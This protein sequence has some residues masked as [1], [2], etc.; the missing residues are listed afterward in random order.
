MTLLASA[1]GLG[2]ALGS[3]TAGR[4]ADA[5]GHTAAFSVT[6]TTTLL[7]TLLLA[8]SQRRLRTAERVPVAG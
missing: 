8:V 5:H 6:V 1:T 7:A 4:L 3:S 2:Y